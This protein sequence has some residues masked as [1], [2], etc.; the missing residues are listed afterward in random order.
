MIFRGFFQLMHN[1]T[2]VLTDEI[3]LH[4]TSL[5]KTIYRSTLHY[6]VKQEI[7][8]SLCDLVSIQ[9]EHCMWACVLLYHVIILNTPTL[10][11]TIIKLKFDLKLNSK[12]SRGHYSALEEKKYLPHLSLQVLLKVFCSRRPYKN[13]KLVKNMM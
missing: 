8:S 2:G 11:V 13:E 1:F 4:T 3:T 7:F 9:T 5:K 10:R 12:G 6:K